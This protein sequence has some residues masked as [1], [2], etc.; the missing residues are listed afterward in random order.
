[1]TAEHGRY[2][3]HDPGFLW[4]KEILDSMH[5]GVV[6]IDARGIIRI[7]NK[8]AADMAHVDREEVLGKKIIEVIPTTGL[9]EILR[10]QKQELNQMMVFGDVAVIS[11]RS[12]IFRD[13]V[14]TGAVGV[15]QNISNFKALS[16]E[17]PYVKEMNRELEA[18]FES[19]ADGIVVGGADGIIVRANK[20]YQNMT[21]VVERE[22]VGKHVQTLLKQGYMNKSVTEIVIEKKSRATVV[23]VRNGK[24]LLI[25]GIP[26][27]DS[28]GNLDKVISAV[29]D[30]TELSDLKKKLEQAEVTKDHYLRE[31]NHMRSQKNLT[32]IITKNAEMQKL[33]ETACYV[34]N[35]DTTVLLLGESGVGKEL[36]AQLIQ[37][38]SPRAG[39]PF[40]KINCGAVPVNLLESEFFGYEPGAFTGALRKGKK[41][42]FEL[43]E[44]G[45]LFLDEVG[46]LPLEL[47]AK[48]LHVIQDKKIMRVGG[49]DIISLNIRIIAATNRDL[50]EM[51]RKKEFRE[52]LYYRLNVV[53]IRIPPLRERREDVTLL[54]MEFLT[55]FNTAYGYQKWITPDVMKVFLEYDWPGNVRELENTVER[56]VVTCRD[57]YIT[58]DALREMARPLLTAQKEKMGSLKSYL[59]GEERRLLEETYAS[60]GSTRKA[61]AVLKMS[62][63]ALV[64]KMKKYD[65]ERHN[66]HAGTV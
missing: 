39:K 56:L 64:K 28:E 31:L 52:D 48:V 59:A 47:Q 34:A 63:S 44:G 43:A 12:P 40:L 10:T 19:V 35:V 7:F 42:L 14:I 2:H 16:Y 58:A 25:T 27:F 13:G 9:P 49:K 32:A 37:R 21:G 50:Q 41:G 24:E 15:F 26:L 8:S 5:N 30:I 61:A 55:R 54:T 20:A 36:I 33:I 53:P 62:Q 18:I 1:M 3:P 22:F 11:N 6:A 65:L 45:T 46:E 4:E 17:L 57:D 38:V 60:A 66:N 29:R 23:D 51:V